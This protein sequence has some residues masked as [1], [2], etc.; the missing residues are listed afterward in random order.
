MTTEDS[1][2]P[3]MTL[4]HLSGQITKNPPLE[5]WFLGERLAEYLAANLRGF[6]ANHPANCGTIT[7]C[8]S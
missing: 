3:P 5:T 2:W 4:I 7:G 1:M 6:L 8:D